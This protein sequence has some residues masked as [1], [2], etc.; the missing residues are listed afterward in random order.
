MAPPRSLIA[1]SLL[2]FVMG[3][4][5]APV[6]SEDDIE[7]AEGASIEASRADHEALMDSQI[8]PL[9]LDSADED[10]EDTSRAEGHEPQGP[11]EAPLRDAGPE[12]VETAA[13]EPRGST[14][15]PRSAVEAGGPVG[16]GCCPEDEGLIAYRP[17]GCNWCQC[18]EDWEEKL[19][20]MC[21]ASICAED[22]DTEGP[23]FDA[24][25]TEGDSSGP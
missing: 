16:E 11:P 25:A 18:D 24:G 10:E 23:G 20:W 3:C 21:T 5:E 12:E 19:S 15:V 14:C 9:N 17:D 6:A 1:L 4:G 13:P 7:A 8:L 2:T 22:A